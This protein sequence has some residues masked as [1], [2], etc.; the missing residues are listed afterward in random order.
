MFQL[1]PSVIIVMMMTEMFSW[2]DD[3]SIQLK[4][5]QKFFSRSYVSTN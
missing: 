5:W 2:H 4:L 1:N 3:W